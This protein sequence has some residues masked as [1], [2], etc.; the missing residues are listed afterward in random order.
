MESVAE[1]CFAGQ[2]G[3]YVGQPGSNL[4]GAL[5]NVA[6]VS[7]ILHGIENVSELSIDT[8][9]DLCACLSKAERQL[10]ALKVAEGRAR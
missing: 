8:L 4:E 1:R 2:D 5:S 6:Y 9:C 7:R 10:S 3:N